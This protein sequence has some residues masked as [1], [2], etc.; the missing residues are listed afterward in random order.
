MLLEP[1]DSFKI[2]KSKE[3]PTANSSYFLDLIYPEGIDNSELIRKEE[4]DNHN[5]NYKEEELE[6]LRSLFGKHII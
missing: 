2:D 5:K 3:M 4:I 6:E 1:S